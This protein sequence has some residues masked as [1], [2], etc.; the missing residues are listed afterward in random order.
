MQNTK[1]KVY[2]NFI[3]VGH[4]EGVSYLVLLLIA[5][6]LKYYMGQPEA[7][8]VVGYL[9]GFLFILYCV[10]LALT[11]YKLKWSFL[12]GLL[13]FVLS[14]IPFGTFFLNRIK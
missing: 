5:M 1:P 9:H 10:L 11:M 6:P 13:A 3:L 12:K 7:V 8:T 14:L 2:K 4:I